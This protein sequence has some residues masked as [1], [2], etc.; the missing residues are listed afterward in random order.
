MSVHMWVNENQKIVFYYNE[1]GVLDLN[2]ILNKD[3]PFTI[4]IQMEWQM[5]MTIINANRKK[6]HVK[7]LL[8]QMS[9]R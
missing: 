6:C 4:W 7:W 1:Y 2:S 8:R 5:Q 9:K 3:V